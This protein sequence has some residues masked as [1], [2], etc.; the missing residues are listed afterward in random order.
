[1][2]EIYV[3]GPVVYGA[4]RRQPHPGTGT[5]QGAG[6]AVVGHGPP[7]VD[8]L[9]GVKIEIVGVISEEAAADDLARQEM[10]LVRFDSGQVFLTNARRVF[11]F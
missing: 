1:M 8:H 6:E 3:L 5:C 11:D 2:F 4:H 9:I 10:P 7:A